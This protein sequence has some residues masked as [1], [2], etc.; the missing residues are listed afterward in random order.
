MFTDKAV[1]TDRFTRV[2]ADLVIDN[3]SEQLSGT[4]VCASTSL[5]TGAMTRQR[6]RL[7]GSACL[8]LFW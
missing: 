2:L 8:A 1:N 3:S 6:S 7:F 5:A 4:F